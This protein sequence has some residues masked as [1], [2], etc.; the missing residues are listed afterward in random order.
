MLLYQSWSFCLWNVPHCPPLLNTWPPSSWR[1]LW[2]LGTPSSENICFPCRHGP[3][4]T[5]MSQPAPTALRAEPFPRPHMLTPTFIT[6][7]LPLPQRAPQ[8]LGWGLDLSI[9]S[10]PHPRVVPCQCGHFTAERTAPVLLSPHHSPRTGGGRAEWDW[11]EE[12]KRGGKEASVLPQSGD[13][14]NADRSICHGLL[15]H[16]NLLSK[17]PT[18]FLSHPLW[19]KKIYILK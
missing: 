1:L 16:T 6:P 15:S 18:L 8:A 19:W 14:W 3:P 4:R 12:R 13:C 9:T 11:E 5:P 7:P 10:L 17:G 2:K